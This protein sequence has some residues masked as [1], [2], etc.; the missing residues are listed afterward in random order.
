MGAMSGDAA[1][2]H[3]ALAH[4]AS[5]AAADAQGRAPLALAAMN[6]RAELVEELLL[7]GASREARDESGLTASELVAQLR[8]ESEEDGDA[9]RAALLAGAAAALS[10][11]LPRTHS[12]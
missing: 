4:G 9:P 8:A 1:L 3:E 6:G 2:V 7:L 5:L 10:A 12:L 11:Q